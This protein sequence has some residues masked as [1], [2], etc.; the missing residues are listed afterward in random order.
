MTPNSPTPEPCS[1]GGTCPHPLQCADRCNRD[2]VGKPAQ[3]VIATVQHVG[4]HGPVKTAREADMDGTHIVPVVGLDWSLYPSG[5][6]LYARPAPEPADP[7]VPADGVTE[8]MV[9]AFWLAYSDARLDD[10]D[11]NG[12]KVAAGLTAALAHATQPAGSS[13]VGEAV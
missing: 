8:Q 3:E 6:L 12:S 13:D 1:Y 5:T 10:L 4:Y 9:R 2:H 7:S 11:A